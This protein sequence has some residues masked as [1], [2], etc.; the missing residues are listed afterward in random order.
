MAVRSGD[1][2]TACPA[3]YVA[4][5]PVVLAVAACAAL[6]VSI[7]T[8][9]R[10]AGENV[11]TVEELKVARGGNAP[12]AAEVV[13]HGV[14]TWRV[15]DSLMPGY[16]TVEDETGGIWV[17]VNLARQWG[18]WAGDETAWSLLEPGAAVVVS[19]LVDASGYAPMIV[20][21]RIEL[22]PTRSDW[23]PRPLEP[24]GRDFFGGVQDC[25]LVHVAGVLQGYRSDARRWILILACDSRRFFATL[26]R[27]GLPEGPEAFVDGMVEITGVATS[28]FTT[29]G[30]FVSPTVHLRSADDIRT[31]EPP[32]HEPFG[33]P[34]VPLERLARYDM[35]SP[36][37]HRVCTEGVVT[38]S[39][40]GSLLYLQQ[41]AV[42]VR[43]ETRGE[44]RFVPGDRVIVTGFIDR[45]RVA[46]G[47]SAAATLV[48]AA[49]RHVGISE[50]AR[51][52]KIAPEEIVAVN[53]RAQRNGLVAVPGD[54]DCCLI[55]FPARLMEVQQTSAGG[56]VLLASGRT[57]LTAIVPT[58]DLY[59]SFQAIPVGSELQV[60]GIVQFDMQS[61]V[62]D[63][64]MWH[65]PVVERMS[66]L[67]RMADD[68][69]V[70]RR[71]S[72]WTPARLGAAVATLTV[73]LAGAI[74]WITLLKRQVAT[75]S[76]R[77]VQEMRQRREAAVEFRATLRERNRLAANLHDTLLQTMS[78]IGMQL[79]ACELGIHEGVKPATEELDRARS[80]V[81]HAVSELRE[82]VWTLRSFPLHGMS[83]PEALRAFVARCGERHAVAIDL[84]LPADLPPLSDFVAGNLVLLVQ[85]AVLNSL[86]HGHPR[87]IR[88]AVAYEARRETIELAVDDDGAGFD[89]TT[90]AGT[91]QGHFGLQGMRERVS[92]LGGEL[93]VVSEP[94]RGTTIRATAVNR[95]Y[96]QELLEEPAEA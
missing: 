30:Q 18:V 27:D 81:D 23:R 6:H 5:G 40:P 66:V 64:P 1:R 16:M 28:R 15:D 91:D 93:R 73:V 7:G 19:G 45:S 11:R 59:E 44:D 50:P 36:S 31:V 95:P 14:V 78:A 4:V 55:E 2:I 86:H 56:A 42:G 8:A 21:V 79:Q 65:L 51:A 70:T 35:A 92:L 71:A 94:G 26:P 77:L 83:F 13:L 3:R 60:R 52:E 34:R 37:N 57:T 46:A 68:L 53:V 39:L 84:R 48:E 96:D 75:Q 74:A 17:N 33:A 61:T 54:Y 49:V 25:R 69:V 80:I 24:F 63:R 10:A 72:W 85:E 32:R 41:G 87:S 76:A 58:P 43:V 62:Q 88:I 22:D 82:S 90:A 47:I 12:D 38:Y 9:A 89:V 20:P 67:I 29:R